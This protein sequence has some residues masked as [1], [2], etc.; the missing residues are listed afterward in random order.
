MKARGILSV[1][2]VLSLVALGSVRNAFA[3]DAA[4]GAAKADPIAWLTSYSEAT[5]R[6]EAE[7]K[8]LLFKFFTGWCPHCTRMDQ[9]TWKDA[10][11]A[12]VAKSFMAAKV[13]ADVEKVPVQRYHLVGYPTVIIA[14]PGGEEVLRLEGYKDAKVVSAFASAYLKRADAIS[15]AHATLRQ[16]KG[17]PAAL[18]SLGEFYA[19]VGLHA[20]A[21]ERYLDAAKKAQGDLLV[22]SRVGAGSALVK[23]KEYKS[24]L[25]SITPALASCG[26]TP[27]PA[28]LLVAGQA[29]AGLG[30]AAAARQHFD[31]LLQLHPQAPE[32]ESARTA[33]AQMGT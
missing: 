29:E 18:V 33:L 23:S 32:A 31:R 3:G 22:T 6:A 13:N 4:A 26:P 1:S 27:P 10:S 17:D 12:E 2:L 28:L 21:A 8:P 30:N 15:A 16:A 7:K 24:A 25:K 14:E 20:Q 19:G 11:L 9:T 5:K